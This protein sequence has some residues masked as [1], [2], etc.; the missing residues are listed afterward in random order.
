MAHKNTES[1]W[2]GPEEIISKKKEFLLPCSYHFYKDPPQLVKG[3][4][5]RL[6][7][8]ENRE[9]LDFFAG[10]SV[11]ACGHCNEEIN[12]R[13]IDQIQT[14]QHTTSI[15]LTQNVVQLAEKLAEVLP[16][17][18]KRSFFCN[19]GSEANEGAMLLARIR[20]GKKGFIA[21]KG[22]LHGRTYLSS[23][24]TGIPMWRSDPSLE[25]L[26]VFFVE[27]VAELRT[28]LEEQGENIA[29]FIFEVLQ[30]N[31]GIQQIS[32]SFLNEALPL[33]KDHGVL[34]IADEIQTGFGRTGKMFAVDHYGFTPDILTGAKAL[35]NGFPIGFFATTDE[36]AASFTRPSA[37]TLGGNPVSAAAGLGVIEYIQRLQLV[38]AAARKGEVLKKGLA[39]L[40]NTFPRL[41]PPRGLGLMLGLEI[42]GTAEIDGGATVDMILERMKEEGFL[43]GKNGLDRNV[44]AFQPPLVITE[45]EIRLMIKTL[46]KIFKELL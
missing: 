2:I 37:S 42:S 20:T 28:L 33:L 34:T 5:S 46:Q 26:P 1:K 6:W 13:V 31:G 16:G 17:D 22:G 4:G 29:G 10:V 32:A 40:A 41:S 38:D 18:L 12:A 35:G 27:S 43:I 19:S 44:L 21:L 45:E 11:M 15:Y 8:S 23:G 24:V 9:Y 36:I 7:D 39:D 14:L 25:D 3:F 30:G